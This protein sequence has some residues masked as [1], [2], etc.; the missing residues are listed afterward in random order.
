MKKQYRVKKNTEIE[1]I[2]ANKK[3]YYNPYFSIYKMNNPKTSHFRYA[4]SVGKKIGKAHERN[5]LKRKIRAALQSLNIPLDNNVDIFIIARA[6]A[7]ELE[8]AL[9]VEQI[10]N[11]LI[12]LQ[13]IKG[14]KND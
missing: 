13:I 2:L 3:S 14:D 12:K 10:K 8:Y 5:Y 6:K 4:I 7:K 9:L 1:A 11:I